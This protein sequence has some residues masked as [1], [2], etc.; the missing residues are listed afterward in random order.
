MYKGADTEVLVVG[1]GF[2]GLS[3][4]GGLD[5]DKCIILD[6]GEKLD[7]GAAS[8]AFA[9]HQSGARHILDFAPSVA[10]E[11]FALESKLAGNRV[12]LPLSGMSCN[13]YSY[14]QGGISNWWGGYASRLTDETLA[15]DGVI[16]WPLSQRDINPFVTRAEGLLHVHGDPR[17]PNRGYAGAMAGYDIWSELLKNVFPA[18]H[19][20]PEAK[21]VTSIKE[22][23]IGL[24]S[25][26]GHCAICINDA[27]ARP[28]NCFE[29]RT[30]FNCTRVNAILFEDRRA[31]SVIAETQGEVFEIGFETL[32]V[33]AGGLE[34]VALLQ[35]SALP[36]DV[37]SDLIGRFY[38]DHTACEILIEM[39]F[40]MPWLAMGAECH[41][42]LPEL[43]GYFHGIE[44]RTLMLSI[45]IEA[46]HARP[47]MLKA[48]GPKDLEGV[49]KMVRRTARLYLQ[50]EIPP[51]WDL[52]VRSSGHEAYIYTMPYL[53]NIGILDMV[54]HE[55]VGKLRDRGLTPLHVFPHYRDGFGGHHYSGT[56]PMSRTENAVVDP[57]QR[58]HGTDNVYINGASVIPR[59]GGAGPTLTLTAL[60]L[61]LGMHL[62]GA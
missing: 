46:I 55:I 42:E 35:R 23:K 28:E 44:V 1:A 17:L 24:C 56:T 33:A 2:A 3:V 58:L 40:D 7:L 26:V 14:V 10:A 54:T 47:L 22:Q 43:S 32:V 13:A 4:A 31:T 20:T 36:K 25:G 6:R 9:R 41:I 27:K 61:R 12:S 34:N 48:Y 60:G 39:P 16:S 52:Q 37:R 30:I 29:P 51:E 19:V 57:T 59:C 15:M 8:A 49:R 50:L 62:A 38:Q 5:P 45:P 18:A 53:K 11:R 21:N